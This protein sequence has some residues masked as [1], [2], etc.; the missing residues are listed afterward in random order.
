[1]P[2]GLPID[3]GQDVWREA[4]YLKAAETLRGCIQF[5]YWEAFSQAESWDACVHSAAGDAGPGG[6]VTAQ[7][8]VETLLLGLGIGASAWSTVYAPES[9]CLC[10]LKL[11]TS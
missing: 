2:Q 7:R 4:D 8:V 11:K 10:C 9:A 1:M 5:C 3:A 6:V